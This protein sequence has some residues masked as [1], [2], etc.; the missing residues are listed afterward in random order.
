MLMFGINGLQYAKPL[1]E[2]L[3]DILHVL[4]GNIAF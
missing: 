3:T 1:L 2:A 4:H